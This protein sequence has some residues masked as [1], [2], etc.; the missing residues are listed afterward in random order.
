MQ[1]RQ[2]RPR[3]QSKR[4]LDFIRSLP[5]LITLSNVGV[6][7]AHI[8][9]GDLKY[10]KRPTGK[11]E[12]PSDRWAV[13][14]HYAVHRTGPDAQHGTCEREWWERRGIDPCEVATALWECS[15]VREAGEQIIREANRR[16]KKWQA[17]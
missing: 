13:P 1:L 15:G 6:E 14:L 16:A 10:D 5:C 4:F 3:V 2:R 8:R 7:A 17:A 11:G 12:R 9:Y